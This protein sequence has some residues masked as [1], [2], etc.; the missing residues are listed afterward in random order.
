MTRSYTQKRRAEQQADT[1]QRIVEA[2]VELH[3]VFGPAATTVRMLAERAGVQRH[4]VYAHF[5]DDRSLFLA[6]SGLASQRNPMPDAAPW[7][8]LADPA[9]RLSAGLGAVYD[10]Y[11]GTAGLA[12]CVLRDSEIHPLTREIAQLVMGPSIASYHEVL[13]E[14]LDARQRAMLHLALGFPTWRALVR[15]SGLTHA[16][17]VDAMVQ[18]IMVACDGTSA[19]PVSEPAT[20]PG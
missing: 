2:A 19:K 9:A 8:V 6:C 5:P 7:R 10:W 14:A 16:Q 12:G 3:S 20:T 4:T 1:R 15:E 18:A 17:A 13:G 11:A